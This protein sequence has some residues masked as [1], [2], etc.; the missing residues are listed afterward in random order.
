MAAPTLDTDGSS[1]TLSGSTCTI[2]VVISNPNSTLVVGIQAYDGSS[3][4]N[5]KV[6]SVTYNGVNLTQLQKS[7]YPNPSGHFTNS[8][9]YLYVITGLATG[10][11]NLVVTFG[12]AASNPAVGYAVYGNAASSIDN[13]NLVETDGSTN[14]HSGSITTVAANCMVFSFCDFDDHGSGSATGANMTQIGAPQ[15]GYDVC[16]SS[17]TGIATPGSVTHTYSNANTDNVILMM[18]SVAP[19]GGGPPPPNT[20]Q[21]FPFF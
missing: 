2:S 17:T 5:S 8:S 3:G 10:T 9:A 14:P 7:E 20:G 11:H 15:S 6:S 16:A 1:T 13:S 12:G 4:A 21:F 19:S 18:A